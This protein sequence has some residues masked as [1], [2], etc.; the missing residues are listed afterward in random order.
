MGGKERASNVRA[1]RPAELFT[2]IISPLIT[3]ISR[4]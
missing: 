2:T 1:A 4:V 3:S